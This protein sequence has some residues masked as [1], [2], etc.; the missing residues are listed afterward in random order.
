MKKNRYS[1]QYYGKDSYGAF[2]FESNKIKRRF[3]KNIWGKVNV[4]Y[5]RKEKNQ[6][7]V[8]QEK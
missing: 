2:I 6:P 3:C 5:Y 4:F 7:V 1:F 8:L